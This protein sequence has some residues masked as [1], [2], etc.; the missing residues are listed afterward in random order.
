MCIQYK[1]LNINFT[2][3]L[4]YV[5]ISFFITTAIS[6]SS[7]MAAHSF[8][9][10]SIHLDFLKLHQHLGSILFGIDEH[11]CIFIK[12]FFSCC[13]VSHLLLLFILLLAIFFVKRALSPSP[14]S[15]FFLSPSVCPSISFSRKLTNQWQKQN[16][17]NSNNKNTTTT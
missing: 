7:P 8:S 10:R 4:A 15:S 3:R 17:S 2:A 13:F 6:S 14:F 11:K 5:C 12:V 9:K 1:F 16:N